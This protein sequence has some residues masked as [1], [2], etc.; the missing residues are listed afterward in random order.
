MTPMV[1]SAGQ[2]CRSVYP[3]NRFFAR[4]PQKVTLNR[5]LLEP[6]RAFG[7]VGWADGR[8]PWFEP[9]A[10]LLDQS[11]GAFL[12]NS[13]NLL[14]KCPVFYF[15]QRSFGLLRDAGMQR[16]VWER[17]GDNLVPHSRTLGRF[18]GPIRIGGQV[19]RNAG[20]E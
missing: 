19:R 10:D 15:S 11:H 12:S 1:I 7:R 5:A 20:T 13:A 14:E 3:D 17:V 2:V 18:L 4:R 6:I 8:F 9:C 16:E